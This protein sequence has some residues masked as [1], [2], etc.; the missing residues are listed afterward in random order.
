MDTAQFDKV[1]G[2]I[3]TVV[4]GSGF[5]DGIERV[6]GNQNGTQDGNSSSLQFASADDDAVTWNIYDFDG[7]GIADGI[8]D[9]EVGGLEFIDFNILEGGDGDDRIPV[10]QRRYK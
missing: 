8:N 2:T 5:F 1:I 3:P 7:V 4:I 9:G 6:V 10:R